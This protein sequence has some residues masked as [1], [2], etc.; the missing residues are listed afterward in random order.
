M[1]TFDES[2]LRVLIVRPG[3][4][5]LDEQGR[6]AGSLDVPLSEEGRTQIENLAEELL[7]VKFD[8]IFTGPSTASLQSAEILADKQLSKLK[9]KIED[10]LKNLDYGLWH[11]KRIDELKE[12]QP[13]L[14]KLWQ[15]QPE[16]VFPPDGET[17]EQTKSRVEKFAKK[18]IKKSKSQT[19]LVV[20]AE[21]IA[22]IL[23]SILESVDLAQYWTVDANCATWFEVAKDY[24]TA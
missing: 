24:Q 13:K 18:L 21:P 17:V 8:K 4:T 3:Q 22:C 20:A 12:T 23:R 7:E 2:G 1:N 14:F 9:V 10:E 5:E 16:S 19:V 11:G 6:I 15:E